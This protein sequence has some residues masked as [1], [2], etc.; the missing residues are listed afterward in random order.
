MRRLFL[1]L[2]AVVAALALGCGDRVVEVKIF[3]EDADCE[4]ARQFRWYVKKHY[5]R[6]WQEYY[7]G[8]AIDSMEAR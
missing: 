2:V 8:T 3:P 4:D 6:I 5:P 7:G 1:V